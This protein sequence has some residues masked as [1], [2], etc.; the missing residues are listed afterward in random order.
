MGKARYLIDHMYAADPVARV[1]NGKLYMYPSHD[2]KSGIPENDKDD[3]FDMRDY[4]VLSIDSIDGGV[5]DHGVTLD[6]RDVR[7]AGSQVWDT[8]AAY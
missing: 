8:G 4:H 2:I 5:T 3:H 7:W 1:F 6:I